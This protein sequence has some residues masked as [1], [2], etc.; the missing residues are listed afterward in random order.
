MAKC[1]FCG[2]ECKSAYAK[3]PVSNPNSKSHTALYHMILCKRCNVTHTFLP[4]GKVATWHEYKEY[5]RKHL[6]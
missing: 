5:H 3:Y 6:L 4:D 1:E 2:E